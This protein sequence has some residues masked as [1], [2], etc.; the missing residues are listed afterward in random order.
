MGFAIRFSWKIVI[1]IW[2]LNF[3][4]QTV[5]KNHT[6]LVRININAVFQKGSVTLD[7]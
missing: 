7:D 1:S 4:K 2:F 3:L 6:Q 5:Q